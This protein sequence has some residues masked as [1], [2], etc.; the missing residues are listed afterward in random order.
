MLDM[1]CVYR[2]RLFHD[3]QHNRKERASPAK[4]E[5]F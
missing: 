1:M 3:C 2:Y 4:N 5:L